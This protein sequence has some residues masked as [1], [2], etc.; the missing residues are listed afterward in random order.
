M[1]APP[2]PA[3]MTSPATMRLEGRLLLQIESTGSTTTTPSH[4]SCR[5]CIISEVFCKNKLLL[6][7]IVGQLRQGDGRTASQTSNQWAILNP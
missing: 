6:A 3:T 7:E 1:R 2:A 5:R 4:H